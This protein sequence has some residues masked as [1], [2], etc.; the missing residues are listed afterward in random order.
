M[1]SDQPPDAASAARRL[2]D[3]RARVLAGEEVSPAEYKAILDEMRQIRLAA[4]QADLR[5]PR[6]KSGGTSLNPDTLVDL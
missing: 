3:N 5:R 1:P 4:A 2:N 6:R